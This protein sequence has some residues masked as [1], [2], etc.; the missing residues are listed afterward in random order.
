MSAAI[1]GEIK[2]A[3]WWKKHKNDFVPKPSK[4]E[5]RKIKL[6]L[7]IR[8]ACK[9]PRCVGKNLT[10][11]RRVEKEGDHSHSAIDHMCG[12]CRCKH[13][14][15]TGTV[16]YGVG[17]CIFHELTER[18]ARYK[19]KIAEEHKMALQQG[20]PDHVYLYK[21]DNKALEEIRQAAEEA[22]DQMSLREELNLLRANMQ[23]LQSVMGSKKLSMKSGESTADMTDDVRIRLITSL[24]TAI[25]KLTEQQLVIT[26]SDYVHAD[27]VRVWLFNIW[28]LI[29]DTCTK[30]VRGQID[31][32][33]FIKTIKPDFVRIVMP[34]TGR[35]KR[36]R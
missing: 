20:Y 4:A 34:K 17:L 35:R 31:P 16:H 12:K 13:I 5:I 8:S 24:A 2:N 27:D 26:E 6:S 15:G 9:L 36:G 3:R 19:V 14:A 10:F 28:K 23:D 7:G 1:D 21:S 11:V 18:Y 33:D 25:G 29:E 30:M 22:G 32:N